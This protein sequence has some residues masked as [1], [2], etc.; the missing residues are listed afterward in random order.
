M[1]KEGVPYPE[2]QKPNVSNA[3]YTF[4]FWNKELTG[5][6]CGDNVIYRAINLYFYLT[7]KSLKSN[8]W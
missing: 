6:A 2:L 8:F 7:K 5:F 3:A 4:P 1:F